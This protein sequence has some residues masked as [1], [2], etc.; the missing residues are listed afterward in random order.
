MPLG[1]TPLFSSLIFVLFSHQ[2][3]SN[4][5]WPY[6]LQH[7]RPLCSSLSPGVCPGSCP[8][9]Q[10]CHP[11]IS[12]SVAL[13]SFCFQSFP[14]SESFP[15]SQLFTSGGQS[16]GVSASASV[17]PVSIQGWFPLGLTGL[18]SLQPEGLSRVFSRWHWLCLNAWSCLSCL[19]M[20]P[21]WARS[22][23]KYTPSASVWEVPSHGYQNPWKYSLF[24]FITC[25]FSSTF[26]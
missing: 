6:G 26:F 2:V 7:A 4:S 9:N 5:L 16:I 19:T 23:W 24:F 11:T 17:L 22:W 8:L 15:M 1:Y 3:V 14:V 13:F 18:I 25:S 21:G 12:S 20:S 10:W